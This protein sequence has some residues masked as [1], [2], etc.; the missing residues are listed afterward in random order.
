MAP[1]LAQNLKSAT[2]ISYKLE[3]LSQKE[4]MRAIYYLFGRKRKNGKVGGIVGKYGGRKLSDGC[5]MI[6]TEN[7]GAVADFFKEHKITFTAMNV[8]ISQ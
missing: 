6:P 2:I 1:A 8:Y 4:K 7:V 3:S 5:F